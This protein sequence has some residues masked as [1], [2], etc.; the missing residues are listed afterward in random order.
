MNQT[1]TYTFHFINSDTLHESVNV[2]TLNNALRD[3]NSTEPDNEPEPL[4][5]ETGKIIIL[6]NVTYID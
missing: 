6:N 2:Q 3:I 5:T 4:I 1:K